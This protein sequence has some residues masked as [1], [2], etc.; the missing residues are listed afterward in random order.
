M[1]RKTQ[2]FILSP[3]VFKIKEIHPMFDQKHEL[4]FE[5]VVKYS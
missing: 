2:Y 3:R 4:E 5:S 1:D